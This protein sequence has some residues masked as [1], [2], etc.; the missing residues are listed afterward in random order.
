MTSLSTQVRNASTN[1]PATKPRLSSSSVLSGLQKEV[2]ALY[3]TI[4]RA[5]YKKDN[6]N[7]NGGNNVNFRK[8]L[9][10]ATSNTRYAKIEFRRQSA[11]LRKNDFQTIEFKIRHGHKQVKLLQMPGVKKVMVGGGISGGG[12][13]K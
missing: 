7:H 6:S 8:A 11:M 1:S 13:T 4:L 5:A 10:D 3:R 12:K 9:Q 2:L